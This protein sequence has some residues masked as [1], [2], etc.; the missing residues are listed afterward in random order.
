[1]HCALADRARLRARVAELTLVGTSVIFL[2][3]TFADNQ[4]Y[5]VLSLDPTPSRI[6][7]GI[8]SAAAFFCSIAILLIDWAGTAAL[9]K[10]AGNQFGRLLM[11]FRQNRLDDETWPAEIAAD[12][13]KEYEQASAN[14]VSIPDKKF[15]SL[16]VHYLTKKEVSAL[17]SRHPGAPLFILRMIVRIRASRSA[18]NDERS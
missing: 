4:L 1:M 17:A 16:K 15:N 12:L 6:V 3:T 8:A 7:L 10:E 5:E 14:S 13:C 9:H 2:A 18:W 11:K